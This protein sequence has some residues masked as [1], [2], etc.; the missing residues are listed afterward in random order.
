M[1]T[2]AANFLNQNILKVVSVLPV[3]LIEFVATRTM[4]VY[5]G[6]ELQLHP[7]LWLAI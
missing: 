4:K 5:G 2:F 3:K 1:P 6:A 7:F